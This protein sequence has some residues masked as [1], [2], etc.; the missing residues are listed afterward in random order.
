[1]GEAT[2]GTHEFRAAWQTV[3]A[4]LAERGFTTIAFEENSGN[5]SAVDEWV[6]GGPGTAEDA[7]RRFGFRLSR[8][9]EMVDLI[10]W[11]RQFNEG[12]PESDRV[13]LY[14]IDVQTSRGRQGRSRSAG[15]PAST[16]TPPAPTPAH[17]PG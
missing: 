6:Q 2:H 10:T 4:Q 8:T 11:A 17:S 3:A 15:S 7:V 14:G 16:R 9:Q 1:M 12:R 5:V 13:Q